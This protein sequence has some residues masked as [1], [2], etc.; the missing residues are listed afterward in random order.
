M[1]APSGASACGG[2]QPAARGFGSTELEPLR[3]ST[4]YLEGENGPGILVYGTGGPGDV[5]RS[6][7]YWTLSLSTGEV[8]N[9]GS[10]VP[11]PP[12]SSSS[13]PP[14]SPYGC[15]VDV[16]ASGTSS[17]LHIVD[18]D[19]GTETDIANFVSVLG[20]PARMAP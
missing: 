17:T 12:S 16:D 20:V 8:Q 18:N 5:P 9:Y 13:P 10:A 7:T 19:T 6:A 14:P 15:S 2:G 3:D 1:P 11:P 4:L